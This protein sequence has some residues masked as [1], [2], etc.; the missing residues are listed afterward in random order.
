MTIFTMY[1]KLLMKV[2]LLKWMSCYEV[3]FNICIENKL[4][5]INSKFSS[6]IN[7]IFSL[8]WIWDREEQLGLSGC[9]PKR[10][11]THYWK[12]LLT[13]AFRNT[14]K[15]YYFWWRQANESILRETER[16][17]FY[18]LC[19]KEKCI[20]IYRLSCFQFSFRRSFHFS[21]M[22]NSYIV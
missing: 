13:K 6:K 2:F 19:I 3:K 21:P 18:L 15:R 11:C 5:R 22:E 12:F 10:K 20:S 9:C 7:Q 14:P 17:S 4:S 1:L 16:T 8:S